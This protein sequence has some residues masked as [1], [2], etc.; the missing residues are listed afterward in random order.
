MN[1]NLRYRGVVYNRNF[2]IPQRAL[3][4]NAATQ[5]SSKASNHTFV[6]LRYRGIFYIRGYLNSGQSDQLRFVMPPNVSKLAIS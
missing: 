2:L 4:N 5:L 3:E 6:I 1:I